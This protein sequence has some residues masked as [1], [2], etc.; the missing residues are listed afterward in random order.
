VTDPL[1]L[2]VPM[3]KR[4]IATGRGFVFGAARPEP[5]RHHPIGVDTRGSLARLVENDR[6]SLR[7]NCASQTRCCG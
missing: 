2:I 1:R 7:I 4:F 5:P 6:M 3:L